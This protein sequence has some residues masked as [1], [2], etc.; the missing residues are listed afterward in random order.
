MSRSL[1]HL[2]IE[3]LASHCL[4]VKMKAVL[5]IVVVA[6]FLAVASAQNL[7][8]AQRALDLANCIRMAGTTVTDATTFCNNCGNSLISYFNDCTNGVGTAGV[9]TS[10]PKAIV[11]YTSRPLF[12]CCTDWCSVEMSNIIQLLC[13]Y[14]Y[15]YARCPAFP[16]SVCS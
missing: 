12:S 5:A 3:S 11:A 13:N 6:C 16:F 2:T 1:V 9:R 8:C 10:K 14:Y 4:T 15:G 7:N